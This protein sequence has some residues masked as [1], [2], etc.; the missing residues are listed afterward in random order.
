MPARLSR[1]VGAVLLKERVRI[2]KDMH[3]IF[4]ADGVFLEVN[5]FEAQLTKPEQSHLSEFLSGLFC[6]VRP[7]RF[8]LPTY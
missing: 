5:F 4:K 2:L 3:R 8:E 1:R 6:M 7:E